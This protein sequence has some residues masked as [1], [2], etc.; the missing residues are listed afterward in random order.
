M[1]YTDNR[2]RNVIVAFREAVKTRSLWT[3]LCDILPEWVTSAARITRFCIIFDV[4]AALSVVLLIALIHAL[5]RNIMSVTAV[6]FLGGLV[7]HFRP[8]WEPFYHLYSGTAV[9]GD[10]LKMA[11]EAFLCTFVPFAI[12]VFIDET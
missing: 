9:F 5:T 8:F 3:R 10:V 12:Y 4:L 2:W 1:T 11:G 6:E 7:E